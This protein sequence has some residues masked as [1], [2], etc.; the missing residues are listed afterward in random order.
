MGEPRRIV[1]AKVRLIATLVMAT[2]TV[3]TLSAVAGDPGS[4]GATTANPKLTA[5]TQ[6]LAHASKPAPSRLM[7]GVTLD[8]VSRVDRVAAILDRLGRRVTVR[9]VFDEGQPPS[10]YRYAVN[11]LAP[12]ADIVGQILDSSAM[13]TV[14]VAQY[15]DRTRRYLAAFGAKVKIWEI[16]NEVNGEWLGSTRSV[17]AKISVAYD[18]VKAAGR[19]A[20]L[21]TYFNP[22]C[23]ERPSHE[24]FRWLNTNV[25]V[26]MKRGL[27]YVFVSYYEGD[28]NNYRPASWTPVFRQL[29][30]LF[31]TS[32]LGFGEVGMSDPARHRTVAKARS[33]MAYYY[34]VRPAVP[35]FVGGWFWWYGAQ[36]IFGPAPALLSTFRAVIRT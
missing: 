31:T 18:L 6:P 3:T 27:D 10:A 17:V 20:A 24:M 5:S 36:D 35:G 12:R 9:I 4:A 14:T 19:S 28:C 25:P 22:D 34:R 7:Y 2:M 13:R 21:T 32:A 33:L 1:R 30:K 16:G 15:A 26:R 23:W 11:R 29:R 8:D